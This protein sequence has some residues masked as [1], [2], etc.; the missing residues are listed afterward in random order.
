MQLTLQ[1]TSVLFLISAILSV[2]TSPVPA[3]SDAL[4]LAI[5]NENSYVA[6]AIDLERRQRGGPGAGKAVYYPEI[7][8]VRRILMCIQAGAKAAGT[9]AG[10]V[11]LIHSRKA[12][13]SSGANNYLGRWSRS[14]PP[15]APDGLNPVLQR[16]AQ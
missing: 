16:Y 5:R 14:K 3:N 7:V 6:R 2:H 8:A 4:D 15:H 11:S 10:A 1:T 12:C 13:G 9:N